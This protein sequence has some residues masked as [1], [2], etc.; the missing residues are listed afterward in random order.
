M[1]FAMV[2]RETDPRCAAGGPARPRR[3]CC[4]PRG[5]ALRGCVRLRP[6][7]GLRHVRVERVDVLL[8]QL[9]A[10]P[11]REDQESLGGYQP[12]RPPEKNKTQTKLGQ[13]KPK[14]EGSKFL[15]AV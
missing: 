4:R 9:R 7:S 8:G 1:S 6:P 13:A 14:G 10:W 5:C 11:P 12:R 15:K 3:P 2:C